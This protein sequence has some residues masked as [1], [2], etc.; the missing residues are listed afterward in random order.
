[1]IDE[2]VISLGDETD[3]RSTETETSENES[4]DCDLVPPL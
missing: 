3:S 2:I 4:N 1:V